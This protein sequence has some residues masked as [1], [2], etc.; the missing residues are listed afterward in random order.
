MKNNKPLL[1]SILVI[2]LLAA[3]IAAFLW[4]TVGVSFTT[5]AK[6]VL[7]HAGFSF[8]IADAKIDF[9]LWEVRLPRVI[10][11]ILVGA[12]LSLAGLIFQG[13]LRNA[14]ADPFILGISGGAAVG[15]GL[16]FVLGIS[17]G[18]FGTPL[19]AF[20]G[21]LI[22]TAIVYSVSTVDGKR[23]PETLILAGVAIG[24]L[25]AAILALMIL[26][27]GK[28]QP[29][30]FWILGSF[31]GVSWN[32]V[33]IVLPYALIGFILA[34]LFVKDLNAM[35]LGDETAVSLGIEVERSRTILLVVGS[36][37]AA[38]AV[39]LV[40]IIGFVGLI[41][42]HIL[43]L[44]FGTNHRVLVPLSIIGGALLLVVSDLISRMVVSPTELP[45]GIITAFIGAP[46]FI[47]LLRRRRKRDIL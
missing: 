40:G 12:M 25:A 1:I 11:T 10:M 19:F 29:I 45:I 26:V 20:V 14:L 13:I 44:I 36:L 3:T 27:S 37:L 43:R 35:L 9:I 4:G 24:S 33:M 34:M 32:E 22:A 41:V 31:S 30:Y 39:S 2:L 28:L 7:N 23:S 6:V 46:F 42:P 8:P 5:A 21:A 15:A 17:L 38:A 16:A 18:F 47:Y